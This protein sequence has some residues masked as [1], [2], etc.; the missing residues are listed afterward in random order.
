[1]K[2]GLNKIIKIQL[3]EVKYILFNYLNVFSKQ[4]KISDNFKG[5]FI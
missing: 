4:F 3:K 1:M 5:K 2:L